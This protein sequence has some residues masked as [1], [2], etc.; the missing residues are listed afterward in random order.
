VSVQTTVRVEFSNESGDSGSASGPETARH[1]PPVW[2][3]EPQAHIVKRV[4]PVYPPLARQA[5]IQGTVVLQVLI[6]KEGNVTNAQLISGHPMLAPAAIEAVKQ[7]KYVPFDLNG[8][9]V[10]VETTVQV[11]F[12]LAGGP[13]TGI[14][15]D[16]P[17]GSGGVIGSVPAGPPPALGVEHVPESVIRPLRIN[18]IDPVYPAEALQQGVQGTVLVNA[19]IDVEGKVEGVFRV[20]GHPMLLAAAMEAVKQWKYIPYEKNGK[21]MP[22]ATVVQLMFSVE[23]GEGVISEPDPIVQEPIAPRMGVP[24]RVRVSSGVS[25]GLLMRKVQPIY[26]PEAREEHIQ[27]KVLLHVNID[28][29]GNVSNLEL[30]SGDSALAPAAID[31]VKQWKYRPYLLNGEAIEVDTQVLINFTLAQ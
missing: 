29:E 5:R 18:K 26:P 2:E 16:A 6:D 21:L 14:D 23:N 17:G 22:V 12:T 3:K 7:W 13:P 25:S 27:G 9:T 15:G 31:A 19:R 8:E 4:P 11:N 1:R 24:Q 28:K 20:S 30:I 10:E